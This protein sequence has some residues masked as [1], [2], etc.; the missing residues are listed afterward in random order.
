MA[1]RNCS[2]LSRDCTCSRLVT[3]PAAT[4]GYGEVVFANII[5]I[6]M[7]TSQ[8]LPNIKQNTNWTVNQIRL[9]D[10]GFHNWYRF[11]LAY[12]PHLVR[13]YIAEFGLHNGQ[14]LLD[15]FV[16]TGT[17]LI[18]AKL[19]G[20]KGIG[21]EANPFAAFASS[22]KV[23]WAVSG[24][25]L[26][27]IAKQIA[28]KASKDIREYESDESTFEAFNPEVWNLLIKD[29]INPQSLAKTQ[30]IKINI[31]KH[32]HHP[33]YKHL[34]LALAKSTVFSVSNLRFGPEVGVGKMKSAAD[35]VFLWLAE[36]AAMANDL[37]SIEGEKFPRAEAICAD[38]R[39]LTSVIPPKS[40]DAIITSPPY[41]N[42]KDYSRT[43]RLESVLLGFI[44]NR[45]DLQTIKKSFIRSNT[46]SIY[47]GDNDFAWVAQQSEVEKLAEKIEKRRT[48]LGKTSGFEKL[49]PMVTKE[50][51]G[52]MARHLSQLRTILRPGAK[53]AYVVG[54]QASYLRVM[55]RT[56]QT[57]GRI[58]ETLGYQVEKI[59]LFRERF[60][61]ATK[62]RLREEVV[63]LS[64]NGRVDK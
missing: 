49:Y 23:D 22:V 41:P 26:E 45:E 11:V 20:I 62:E 32:S 17:T 48:Q 36:I 2:G 56:G 64:W 59:D 29:S 63:V 54:D 58:A 27:Q 51:F 61:S 15:P 7:K 47:K 46:R 60:A 34:L 30:I 14:T 13:K 50:Y 18:E 33:C 19:L 6:N 3:Q 37:K 8:K 38:S 1:A 52:G 10:S 9:T 16:G 31:D 35:V 25:E 28:E 42:E 5:L 24:S 40:I 21:V 43:T 57:L 12:P 53:L 4:G 44:K 39:D 55:I